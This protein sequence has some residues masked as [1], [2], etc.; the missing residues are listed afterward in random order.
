MLFASSFVSAQETT[1]VGQVLNKSDNSPI[2][3]VNISFKNTVQTVQ[4]N[5]EGYFF[6]RT[7]GK[8]TNLVFSCIGFQKRELK[9][10]PGQ[11]IGVQVTMTEEN[12]LLQEAFIFPGANPAI[13]FM[14]KVRMMRNIND[15]SQRKGF[16]ANSTEQNLVLLSKI[17]QHSVSNRIFDQLKK[18]NIA[19]SDSSLVVP[20]YMAENDYQLTTKE[21]KE[22][23]ENIYSSSESSVKILKKLVGELETELN[24][25]DNSI[26]VFG[27][28]MVSPLANVGNAYYN[29]FLSDSLKSENGKQ[30]EIHFR[31]KNTKNLAFDGKLWIDSATFALTKIEAELP[32]QA[33]INFIHNLRI[34]QQFKILPNRQWVRDSEEMELKMNYELLADS[35]HPRPEIFVKRSAVFQYNKSDLLPSGNFAKSNYNQTILNEKLNDL[36]NTPLLRT[37]KWI[38]DILFTGYIPVGKIDIGKIE[39]LIRLTDIEGWRLTLPFR[40]N[41]KLWKNISL[42]GYVG[43]GF[44]NET[45]KYSGLAEFKIPSDKWRVISLNY[46]DDYRRIDYNYNDF[47]FR[48]NPL[49]TGD[50]DI[51][52]SVFALKSA[53][54][55]SERKEFSA[56]FANDWNSDIKSSFYL[57]KN[58]LFANASMPMTLKGTKVADFLTQQSATLVTR[59]SFN[60]RNYEDNTQRIY[61]SNNKPVIYSILEAGK[62]QVGSISGNYGKII[63][64]IKQ[65]VRFYFGQ[66]NYIAEAGLIIGNVPYQLL[67]IPPGSETGGYCDYQFNMM[68]YMEYAA[69]KYLNLHSELMLNG[70]LLNQIPLIKELNLREMCS[71]NLAYGS[72]NDSHQLQL[73]YPSFMHPLNKP[74]MEIGVGF[75]NIL[76]LF[77]LQSVWRLTDLNHSAVIPW[78]IRG[79]LS[80]N[81]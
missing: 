57:R 67:E 17:T 42:G 4:T 30:Y 26:T 61:I 32:N 14:K 33:N 37:A 56:S 80:L 6:I 75:T 52:S 41:E 9:I 60:E 23:S 63:G 43:Y 21:K 27:K 58:Q 19:R 53:G 48:E 70:L 72:L 78:G 15:I 18:G 71:F 36:N 47:M 55:I 50:E 62:Y 7:M 77:T 81:F 74:Y 11:S 51:S 54:K 66:F 20:L 8:Q 73:D 69:D 1:V 38:A 45:V 65:N 22:L 49:I 2:S 10:K 5:E 28:S 24:F 16:N 35:L 34:L 39:Q 59:F 68:N 46:T 25:Y 76:N 31:S 44:K 12:T 79:C 13:G 3:G 40:T 64:S 29:Y